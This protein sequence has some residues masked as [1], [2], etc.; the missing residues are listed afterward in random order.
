MQD[1]SNL[2]KGKPQVSS[3]L[4]LNT[5]QSG[6]LPGPISQILRRHA[7]YPCKDIRAVPESWCKSTDPPPR[8]PQVETNQCVA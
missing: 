7:T 2:P 4:Y 6:W 8:T 5:D 1:G 3:I